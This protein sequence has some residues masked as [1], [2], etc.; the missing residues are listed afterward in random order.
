[1]TNTFETLECDTDILMI[2][3]DTFTVERF[4]E[5]V[6]DKTS[7]SLNNRENSNSINTSYFL[8]RSEIKIIDSVL[9]D[10]KSIELIFPPEGR[11]CK[12]LKLG[13]SEW[14]TGKIRI[15][16]MLTQSANYSNRQSERSWTSQ[17]KVIKLEF[18]YD[19]TLQPESPLD[20]IRQR[21]D[22]QQLLNNQ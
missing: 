8:Y 19:E 15:H 16:V 11:E 3:K 13:S 22:Y 5:L 4:K 18:C 7:N 2:G 1:M 14:Q 9:F 6:V 12:L 21:E 17:V 20:D 10:L